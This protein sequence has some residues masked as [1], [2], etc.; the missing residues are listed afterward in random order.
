MNT[1]RASES[2]R[3]R[4]RQRNDF[5]RA[6][7]RSGLALS[8]PTITRVPPRLTSSCVVALS[9]LSP[10]Y[11]SENYLFTGGGEFGLECTIA[12]SGWKDVRNDGNSCCGYRHHACYPKRDREI[13]VRDRPSDNQRVGRTQSRLDGD[14][15]IRDER[16]EG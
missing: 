14:G 1:W 10:N 12:R 15:H 2:E 4:P 7:F 5:R 13:R 6:R 16:D 11:E 8:R 9:A 3:Y